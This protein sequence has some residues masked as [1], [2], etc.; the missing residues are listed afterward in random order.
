MLYS[1]LFSFFSF[2]SFLSKKNQKESESPA[3]KDFLGRC[4]LEK[5][6]PAG[7][8]NKVNGPVKRTLYFY[9]G[10]PETE[11]TSPVQYNVPVKNDLF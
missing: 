6:G 7:E 2:Y 1:R 10:L 4:T 5:L 3:E 8:F 9:F 11:N